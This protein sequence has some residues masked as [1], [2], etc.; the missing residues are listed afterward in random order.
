MV[1]SVTH[2]IGSKSTRAYTKLVDISH[3]RL[4]KL[5][6]IK[7]GQGNFQLYYSRWEERLAKKQKGPLEKMI[8]EVHR[9]KEEVQAKD[10]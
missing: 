8:D 4:A 5:H 7:I 2:T 1:I 6:P 10:A 9:G 3:Q